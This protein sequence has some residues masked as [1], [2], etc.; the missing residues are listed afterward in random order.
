MKNMPLRAAFLPSGELIVGFYDRVQRFDAQGTRVVAKR[1]GPLPFAV[2]SSGRLFMAEGNKVFEHDAA[3]LAPKGKALRFPADRGASGALSSLAISPDD[4]TLAGIT[5][6]DTLHV[7]DLG[8]SASESRPGYGARREALAF[9]GPRT[10]LNVR[11]NTIVE[12]STLGGQRDAELHGFNFAAGAE[13]HFLAWTVGGEA[14]VFDAKGEARGKLAL[15]PMAAAFSQGLLVVASEEAVA[16]FDV[17]SRKQRARVAVRSS[18]MLAVGAGRVAIGT[19]EAIVLLSFPELKPLSALPKPPAPPKIKAV[20]AP[21]V[22]KQKPAKPSALRTRLEQLGATSLGGAVTEA[23]L[24]AARKKLGKPVFEPLATVWRDVDGFCIH[25]SAGG[26]NGLRA[27]LETSSEDVLWNDQFDEQSDGQ[28]PLAKLKRLKVLWSLPGQAEAVGID[29]K[30]G[31]L[32]FGEPNSVA[33]L[34]LKLREY[35][36][37]ALDPQFLEKIRAR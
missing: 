25:E 32:F 19:N 29:A 2:A 1:K 27:L 36:E 20:S 8:S 15:T 6:G 4:S 37:L 12:V 18:G 23:R 33:P 35:L 21:K 30:T 22:K 3:T 17:K 5:R 7:Q 14:N 24:A 9:L 10:V 26:L 11:G 28:V 16:V 34:K 31:A 13:G